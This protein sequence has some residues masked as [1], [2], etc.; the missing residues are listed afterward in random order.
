MSNG[1]AITVPPT[2]VFVSDIEW[3][4]A[5]DITQGCNP[6]D[7]DLFCPSDH[8]TRGQMAAFLHRAFEG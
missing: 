8:V 3:L 2:S 5:V 1:S 4:S 6:P 7:G